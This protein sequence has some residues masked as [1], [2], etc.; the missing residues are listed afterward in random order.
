MG[1]SHSTCPYHEYPSKF[2]SDTN[3][4][5]A[6]RVY[7]RRLDSG[8][9]YLD[10]SY[11]QCKGTNNPVVNCESNLFY[12]KFCN[13]FTGGSHEC[14]EFE[15]EGQQLSNTNRYTILSPYGII[16]VIIILII[17]YLLKTHNGPAP[18]IIK[19]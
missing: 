17:M 7:G 18:T 1:S 6:T 11:K 8:K 12:K 5:T 10:S 3:T 2:S 4:N 9:C 19:S 16:L 15:D 14:F 13:F